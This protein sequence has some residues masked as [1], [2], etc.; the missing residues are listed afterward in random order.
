MAVSTVVRRDGPRITIDTDHE[1]TDAADGFPSNA[2]RPIGPGSADAW[3]WLLRGSAEVAVAQSRVQQHSAGVVVDGLAVTGYTSYQLLA[4]EYLPF[5]EPVARQTVYTTESP[6]MPDFS[7]RNY[8][9]MPRVD[10]FILCIQQAPRDLPTGC[11]K[12]RAE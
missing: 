5:A 7:W 2:E 12:P 10:G 11:Q 8:P 9:W 4:L 3:R 1:P 6:R